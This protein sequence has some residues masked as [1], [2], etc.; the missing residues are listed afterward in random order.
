MLIITVFL[1]C[2]VLGKSLS[3]VLNIDFGEQ[4]DER[5]E[6]AEDLYDGVHFVII[7]VVYIIYMYN[8]I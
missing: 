8:S 2:F 5:A 3:V 4:N 6:Y 7:L 1:F